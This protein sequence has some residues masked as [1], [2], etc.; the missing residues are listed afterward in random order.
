M[1]VKEQ[2]KVDDF[3]VYAVAAADQAIADAGDVV[4][5]D[6][7]RVRSGVLIGSGIGGLQT[8]EMGVKAL[9][10]HGPRRVHP[11]VI[12]MIITNMASGYVAI[13]QGVKGPNLCHVSACATGAHAL[14][15]AARTVA[16]LR[17]IPAWAST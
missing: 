16:M 11:F 1:D 9:Y 6:A 13:R 17:S 10:K 4:N 2:R 3:I 7:D 8:L 15:E 12:P 5:S 14:G